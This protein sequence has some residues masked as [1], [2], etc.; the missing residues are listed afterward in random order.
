MPGRVCVDASVALMLLLRSEMEEK[1]EALWKGWIADGVT[2]VAPPLF[3]AEVT[4]VLRERE[5]RGDLKPGEASEALDIALQLPVVVWEP[6]GELQRRAYEMAAKYN[7]PKA[8]DAQY[9]AVADLLGCEV[10]TADR[11]LVRGVN[12]PW[13][14]WVGDYEA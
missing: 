8:Y 11:R 10:W 4:S 6:D 14:R 1:A 3:S 2:M 5:Y 7:R 13:V 12:Q 9:L